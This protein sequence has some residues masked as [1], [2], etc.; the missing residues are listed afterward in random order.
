VVVPPGPVGSLSASATCPLGL[1]PRPLEGLGDLP[2]FGASDIDALSCPEPNLQKINAP[3]N[4]YKPENALNASRIVFVPSLIPEGVLVHSNAMA[5]RS[6]AFRAVFCFPSAPES[7]GGSA[8]RGKNRIIDAHG[9]Q[10]YF[11]SPCGK[12]SKRAFRG[13]RR[14]T[15]PAFFSLTGFRVVTRPT[16]CE[17]LRDHSPLRVEVVTKLSQ[18]G[19]LILVIGREKNAGREEV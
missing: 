12:S 11:L 17:P 7:G 19:K 2:I 14:K 5:G 6:H 9:Q 16:A 4:N 15:L 18:W 10:C 1:R 3:Q 8:R 13:V